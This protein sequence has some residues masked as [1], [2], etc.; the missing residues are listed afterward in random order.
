MTGNKIPGIVYNL[1]LFLVL[2]LAIIFGTGCA[3]QRPQV[4]GENVKVERPKKRSLWTIRVN[5]N[6]F[7]RHLVI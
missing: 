7:P 4:R 2:L 5:L 3:G 1:L 6:S